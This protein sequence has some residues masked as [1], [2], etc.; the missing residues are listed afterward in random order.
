MNQAPHAILADRRKFSGRRGVFSA[1]AGFTLVEMLVV[2]T[3]IVGLMAVAAA[4]LNS[5]NPGDATKTSSSQ[6]RGLAELTQSKALSTGNY[7][8]LLICKK[9]DAPEDR[10]LRYVIVVERQLKTNGNP[11]VGADYDWVAVSNGSYLE[12]GTHYWPDW[13]GGYDLTFAMDGTLKL[14]AAFNS[15]TKSDWIGL[16][17]SPQGLPVE[18]TGLSPANLPE[19]PKFIVTLGLPASTGLEVTENDK[20][21]SEGFMIQRSNGR[22]VIIES[23]VRQLTL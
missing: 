16:V 10:C 1:R 22:T 3:I 14:G 8:A 17:F 13:G 21:L 2:I 4:R 5:S 23:P 19:N 15:L 11:A 12:R 6:L 9:F 20:K 7:T 18:P